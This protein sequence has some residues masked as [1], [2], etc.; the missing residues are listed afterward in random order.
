[1]QEPPAVARSQHK[2]TVVFV[3]GGPGAGKGTQCDMMAKDYGFVHLSAGDLLRAEQR[4]G[5]SEGELIKS[6][7]DKGHIV[8]VE[9]TVRL[10]LNA[11][12]DSP[13]SRFLIDGFPR[14][15]NN[16]DGWLRLAKDEAD[17]AMVLF[18][19]VDEETRMK[20]LLERGKS[21]G[22]SDDNRTVIEERFRVF[23]N[24]TMPIV[25]RYARE[26]KVRIIDAAPSQEE[27]YQMT[28]EAVEPMVRDEV[29]ELTQRL[30]DAVTAGDYE[31]YTA[32]SAHDMTAIEEESRGLTVVGRD[33][34]KYYFDL[35]KGQ[36]QPAVRNHIVDPHVRLVNQI[37]VVSYTRL[38]Q[39]R[40]ASRR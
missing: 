14:N 10:L 38:V 16:L 40:A 5:T 21:S 15:E 13:R 33:F 17:V 26:G 20:R 30:I 37:A 32:L 4:K 3:L 2:P 1:M 9:I 35:K 39:V 25:N 7:I 34:H 18:Y 8:P 19:D 22:R 24:D 36:S 6:Y 23:L 29:V 27:V 12:R 28:K 31:T 11:I